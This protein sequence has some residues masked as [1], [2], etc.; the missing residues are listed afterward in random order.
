M[1][2]R[3]PHQIHN[4]RVLAR[5]K[6]IQAAARYLRFCGFPVTFARAV[7]ARIN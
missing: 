4:A 5:V 6:S 1:I 7:L 2:Y 3:Q